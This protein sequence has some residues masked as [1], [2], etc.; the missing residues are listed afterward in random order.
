MIPHLPDLMTQ[1]SALW[2]RISSLGELAAA[3]DDVEERG[4]S[5]AV[6]CLLRHGEKESA[7]R[8]QSL[9][10]L[11]RVV[12][13][14]LDD[15]MTAYSDIGLSIARTAF[16]IT[17]GQRLQDGVE[18][19]IEVEDIYFH[20]GQDGDEPTCRFQGRIIRKD[21]KPGRRGLIY[22]T[23]PGETK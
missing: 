16:G 3:F 22:L 20:C 7:A 2:G 10:G 6:D 5:S 23:V 17:V 21:G 14:L 1:A 4:L 15:S 9:I 8:L 18:R 11:Q 12:R 13:Q 19:E